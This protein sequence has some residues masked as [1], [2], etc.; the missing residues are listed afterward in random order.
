MR[1]SRIPEKEFFLRGTRPSAK[2]HPK[3]RCHREPS[4]SGEAPFRQ[5]Q[6]PE[7]AEGQEAQKKEEGG[8]GFWLL[9]CRARESARIKVIKVNS[10]GGKWVEGWRIKV[11]QGNQGEIGETG[12]RK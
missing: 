12:D 10:H 9:G 2:R 1:A 3:K 4:L 8:L 7:P 11:D 6:G 5:A